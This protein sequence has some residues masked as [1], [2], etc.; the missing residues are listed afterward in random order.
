[1]S[2]DSK[3]CGKSGKLDFSVAD[4]GHI[5]RKTKIT[6]SHEPHIIFFSHF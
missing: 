5:L 2:K 3:L 4:E 1:M 6:F